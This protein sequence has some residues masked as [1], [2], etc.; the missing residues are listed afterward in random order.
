P[1]REALP[2]GADH[3]ALGSRRGGAVPRL[4]EG[5]GLQRH[6][7]RPRAVPAGLPPPSDGYGADAVGRAAYFGTS[8]S[9]RKR[10][11]HTSHSLTVPHFSRVMA[12]KAAMIDFWKSSRRALRAAL[13]PGPA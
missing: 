9:G 13:S 3:E 1:G 10:R 7:D 2:P 5:R 12:W 4:P 6:G 8:K 11:Y